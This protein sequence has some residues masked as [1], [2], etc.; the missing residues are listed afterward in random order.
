MGVKAFPGD[1]F[2][3][4]WFVEANVKP[5]VITKALKRRGMTKLKYK[6]AVRLQRRRYLGWAHFIPLT[7]LF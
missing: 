2:R 4:G 6:Y 3:I 5:I 7:P 1:G